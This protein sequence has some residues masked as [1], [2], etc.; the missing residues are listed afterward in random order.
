MS[1]T[2]SE[3]RAYGR[4]YNTRASQWP[5]HKPPI[6]PD[7]IVG[8]MVSALRE[9]RDEIDSQLAMFDDNDPLEIALAP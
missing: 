4:G 7:P 5:K 8:A 2:D 9:L 6:P 1:M 3:K